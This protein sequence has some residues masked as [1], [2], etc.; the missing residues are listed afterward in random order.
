MLTLLWFPAEVRMRRFAY[1]LHNYYTG[2]A[3]VDS[4]AICTAS[5]HKSIWP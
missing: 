3:S 5:V 4:A 1:H 2:S